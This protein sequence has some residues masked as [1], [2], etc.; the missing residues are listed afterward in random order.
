MWPCLINVS[1]LNFSVVCTFQKMWLSFL[2]RCISPLVLALAIWLREPVTFAAAVTRY[3][4]SDYWVQKL[5]YLIACG[6][7]LKFPIISFL[8]CGLSKAEIV[9]HVFQL[10]IF[11]SSLFSLVYGQRTFQVTVVVKN[12]PASAGDARD[13]GSV[14]GSGRSPG[15]GNGNPLQYSC[16]ENSMDRGAWWATVHG[17][18]ESRTQPSD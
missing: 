12:P 4:L 8:V 11:S 3:G 7:H 18:A 17:A 5:W 2:T 9:C 13:T 16:L 10:S 14:P 1:Q 15:I 6:G